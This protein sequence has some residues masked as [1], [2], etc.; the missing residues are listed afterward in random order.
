MNDLELVVKQLE[1]LTPGIERVIT[2]SKYN[3]YDDL[4]GL[5]INY[6]D[7]NQLFLQSELRGILDKLSFIK[8]EIG[9][10]SKP[11]RCEGTLR[12]NSIGK[13][14]LKNQRTFSCGSSLEAYIFDEFEERYQWVAG[15][16][17]H[18]GED[19]YLTGY[20]RLKLEGLKVRIR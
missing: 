3:E 16:I 14:E 1:A 13:Y 17:E 7:A 18:N 5:E 15:V 11:V 8:H 20:R 10:L 12:K 6:N 2:F 9:Y 19:Y 4:S